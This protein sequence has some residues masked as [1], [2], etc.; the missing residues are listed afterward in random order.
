MSVSQLKTGGGWIEAPER[1]EVAVVYD[2]IASRD[3]AIRVCD[4]LAN[5]FKDDL[6][7]EFTWWNVRFFEDPAIEQ[8]AE[9]AAAA[10][11]LIFFSTA[12]STEFTPSNG[13]SPG[14][15]DQFR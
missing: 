1:C 8:L 13:S 11:D 5:R 14:S 9:Q 4:S 3:R 6:D 12:R 7:F 15:I 2:D 10:A